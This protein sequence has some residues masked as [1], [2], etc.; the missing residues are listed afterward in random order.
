MKKSD[1]H[2]WVKSGEYEH[3]CKICGCVRNREYHNGRTYFYYKR[4]GIIFG[5]QRPDCIDWN[6]NTLD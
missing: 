3:T 6:D 4:S 1:K 2:A 5:L